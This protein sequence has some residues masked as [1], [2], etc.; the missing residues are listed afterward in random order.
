MLNKD[1]IVAQVGEQAKQELGDQKQNLW[2]GAL[3][4]WPRRVHSIASGSCRFAD[5]IR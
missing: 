1:R 2:A 4:N 3:L 5:S